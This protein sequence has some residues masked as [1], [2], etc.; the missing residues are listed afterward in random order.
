MIVG[1][2][3]RCAW[4]YLFVFCFFW[5]VA[6][7]CF[8]FFLGPKIDRVGVRISGVQENMPLWRNFLHWVL[9][10]PTLLMY[11]CVQI[12]SAIEG[13]VRGSK[14]VTHSASKKDAL[15]KSDD[16]NLDR[17]DESQLDQSTGAGT[18]Y[19]LMED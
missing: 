1:V 7:C 8:F 14:V 3:P 17:I 11:N 13:A 5:I 18:N 9:V 12:F 15:G 4:W 2:V 19:V 6:G 16:T 10:Y